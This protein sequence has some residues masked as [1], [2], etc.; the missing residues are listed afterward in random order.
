MHVHT[1]IHTPSKASP[2][3][4]A[5]CESVCVCM[6]VCIRVYVC[7][8]PLHSP[9]SVVESQDIRE[10]YLLISSLSK[11][12]RKKEWMKKRK[13]NE[14]ERET[15]SSN[16][17]Y[18]KGIKSAPSLLTILYC[19]QRVLQLLSESVSLHWYK[20]RTVEEFKWFSLRVFHFSIPFFLYRSPSSPSSPFIHRT[21]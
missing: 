21:Q 5:A 3:C 2:G 7:V 9:V 1:H 20:L 17:E 10:T 19:I 8:F 18:Q 16:I 6:C 13:T 14:R 4:H 12:K 15:L 11:T